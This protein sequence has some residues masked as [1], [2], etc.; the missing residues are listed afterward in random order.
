[1]HSLSFSHVNDCL[2]SRMGVHHA[3]EVLALPEDGQLLNAQW[4]L[5]T[6]LSIKGRKELE[7]YL[8]R[9]GFQAAIWKY[10][11]TVSEVIIII[12]IIIIPLIFYL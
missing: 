4:V 1:M 6:H 9:Q 7:H 5:Q 3:I 12:I 10:V 8:S 11:L 2:T